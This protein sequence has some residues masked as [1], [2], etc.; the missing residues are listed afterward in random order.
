MSPTRINRRPARDEKKDSRTSWKWSIGLVLFIGLVP[1]A[2]A[3]IGELLA[4]A[5]GCEVAFPQLGSCSRG[6]EFFESLSIWLMAMIRWAI[7]SIPAALVTLLGLGVTY[8]IL[9]KR[10]ERS[11]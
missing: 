11:S 10:A 1:L 4:R 8:T 9:K 7:I 6:I 3:F 5:M 2:A